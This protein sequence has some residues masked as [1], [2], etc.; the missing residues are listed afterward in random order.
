MGKARR[1][2]N[3]CASEKRAMVYSVDADKTG[4]ARIAHPLIHRDSSG[5]VTGRVEQ[6]GKERKNKQNLCL[7]DLR[8]RFGKINPFLSKHR[9]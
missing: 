7:L 8:E 3:L 4:A 1:S 5:K 2:S 6:N 9:F